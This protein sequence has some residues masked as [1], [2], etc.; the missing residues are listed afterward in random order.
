M[1]LALSELSLSAKS[2]RSSCLLNR[3]Q[4]KI[5]KD[6]AYYTPHSLVDFILNEKLPWADKNNKSYELKILDPTCGSGIFLVRKDPLNAF[7]NRWKYV[8]KGVEIDYATPKKDTSKF[9]FWY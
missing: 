5:K 4:I 6:G 3:G 8:N 7:V 1:I 9:N 2:M